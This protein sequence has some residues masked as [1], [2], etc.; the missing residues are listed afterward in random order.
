MNWPSSRVSCVFC[1]YSSHRHQFDTCISGGI[2]EDEN[3]KHC[4][5]VAALVETSS[6]WRTPRSSTLRLT[7][8]FLGDTRARLSV[9]K[10]QNMCIYNCKWTH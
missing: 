6:L 2:A 8:F 3:S 4:T 1:G 9:C 7:W 10:Y 5:L